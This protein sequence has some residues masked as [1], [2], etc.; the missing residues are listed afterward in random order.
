MVFSLSYL[1]R[2]VSPP[3][4]LVMKL[5]GREMAGNFAR[6]LQ[7]PR[8]HFRVL[9]HAANMR[10]ETNGFTSLP[11]E[12]VLRI[13]S[14]WKIRRL[15]SGLNPRTWVQKTS[16]LPLDH[17]SSSRKT[18]FA[19]IIKTIISAICG[20]KSSFC[21]NY[22]NSVCTRYSKMQI[23]LVLQQVELFTAGLYTINL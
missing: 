3:E 5:F 17:R 6:K 18:Y 13:F 14:P 7:L 4:T 21:H 22:K 10:H 15:R 12:G 9:L 23:S 11:K 16:T 20:E 19:L 1:H 2:Q 8:I